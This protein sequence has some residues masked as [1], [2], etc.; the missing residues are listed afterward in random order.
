[1]VQFVC[2]YLTNIFLDCLLMAFFSEV[3]PDLERY[4]TSDPDSEYH[5]GSTDDDLSQSR[6]KQ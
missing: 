1:M 4:E 6:R 2:D 3:E 5:S